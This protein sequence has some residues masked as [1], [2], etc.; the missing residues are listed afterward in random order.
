MNPYDDSPAHPDCADFIRRTTADIGTE[1][2]VSTVP[3]IVVGPYETGAF[4]CPH[5]TTYYIEP[6]G[7]Q[8]AAWVRDGVE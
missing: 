4:T 5:G 8:I 7:E 2:H 1:V 6:T 3:P